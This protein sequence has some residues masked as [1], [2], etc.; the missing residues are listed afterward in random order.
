MVDKIGVGKDN[1]PLGA[2]LVALLFVYR[3]LYVGCGRC[4]DAVG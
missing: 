4:R 3:G 1:S 2:V